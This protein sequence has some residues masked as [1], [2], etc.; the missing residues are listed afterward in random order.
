MLVKHLSIN[1]QRFLTSKLSCQHFYIKSQLFLL[2]LGYENVCK[3]RLTA[4]RCILKKK[5]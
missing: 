3:P 1:I 5:C 2:V 4:Y